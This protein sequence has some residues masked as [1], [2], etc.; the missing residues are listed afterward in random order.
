MPATPEVWLRG[1][2]EGIIAEL[3]PVAHA[4]LQA[5]ED[6]ERLAAPLDTGML[7]RRAGNAASIGFHVRHMSGSLDRLLTYARGD[8]LTDAQREA[9]AV[10]NE[11]TASVTAAVL[12]AQLREVVEKALEQLRRTTV[13]ELDKARTV[14]RAALPSSVRGL[15][16]HASEH[17]VRHAGQISTMRRVFDI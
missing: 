8:T 12:L 14:G 1:P 5:L 4:L 13:E 15:L 2:I 16:Y 7:W 17:T 9:L 6:A 10:E 3:Q 11:A